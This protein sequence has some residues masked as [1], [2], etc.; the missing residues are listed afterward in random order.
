MNTCISKHFTTQRWA[1]SLLGPESEPELSGHWCRNIYFLFYFILGP[2]PWLQSLSHRGLDE[3]MS[4]M[5]FW[6]HIT[7]FNATL[8]QVASTMHSWGDE[9]VNQGVFSFTRIR[10]NWLTSLGTFLCWQ[11]Q[12]TAKCWV[13]PLVS[14]REGI[15]PLT[16]EKT[17]KVCHWVIKHDA[18]SSNIKTNKS[19]KERGTQIAQTSTNTE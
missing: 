19:L 6:N 11:S 18:I 7:A 10:T 16:V 17:N 5:L 8:E 9:H 13:L 12:N 4:L 3:G 14:L 15:T 1:F 2:N